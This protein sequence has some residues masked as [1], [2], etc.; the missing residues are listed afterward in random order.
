M[1]I[2]EMKELLASKLKD[3][4]TYFTKKHINISKIKNGY[5]IVIEDYEHVPFKLIMEHED[6]CYTTYA[7]CDG[8]CVYFYDSKYRFY[9]WEAIMNIGYYIGTHF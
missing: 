4:G 3:E 9:D 2:N 6:D 8:E 5:K 7:Y 1:T